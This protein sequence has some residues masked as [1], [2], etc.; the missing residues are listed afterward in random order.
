MKNKQI[1]HYWHNVIVK[2]IAWCLW[3]SAHLICV[4]LQCICIILHIFLFLF[5]FLF[6]YVHYRYA[7]FIWS[8]KEWSC[9]REWRNVTWHKKFTIGP[10]KFPA[11][12][13][14]QWHITHVRL[15]S[16]YPVRNL[17]W[18][19]FWAGL[20]TDLSWE[21]KEQLW[22]DAPP[23]TT[24]DPDGIRSQDLLTMSR[25]CYPLS[26]GYSLSNGIC[27]PVLCWPL[28][29]VHKA[30]PI[31]SILD[32]QMPLLR[33]ERELPRQ[34]YTHLKWYFVKVSSSM[35]K[36]NVWH[37]FIHSMNLS[38]FFIIKRKYQHHFFARFLPY[39]LVIE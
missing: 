28:C 9:S 22:P 4:P 21:Q 36:M 38:L 27:F 7:C 3:W 15:K 11:K 32:H 26:H 35:Q 30:I 37:V 31:W 18:A 20:R 24:N 33:G 1:S 13:A 5:P 29:M 14:F 34:N 25:K 17:N 6:N 12:R 8:P 2:C 39:M 10:I 19:F 23:D 16:P